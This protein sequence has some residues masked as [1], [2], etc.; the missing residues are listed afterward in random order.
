M[1]ITINGVDGSG[2]SSV[3]YKLR[4]RITRPISHQHSRPSLIL[5]RRNTARATA[6]IDRPGQVPQR[7]YL[8]QVIKIFLFVVEFNIFAVWHKL[9]S[10]SRLVILERSLIDLKIHPERYGLSRN[11]ANHFSPLLTEWYTDIDFR[12]IGDSQVIA[13]RKSDL[14]YGEIAALNAE[15]SH[16]INGG[17][18]LT[19]IVDTTSQSEEESS[20]KMA[21]Q[22]RDLENR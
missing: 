5:R 19:C 14:S 8:L 21:D 7:N 12:L 16:K 20:D 11:L 18:G 1:I 17:R 3:I 10:K 9:V 4:Q 2:K 13:A 22:I 6:Y 15:Y